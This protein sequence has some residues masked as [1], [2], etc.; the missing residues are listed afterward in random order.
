M[1]TL[2]IIHVTFDDTGKNIIYDKLNIFFLT[3]LLSIFSTMYSYI[4][5]LTIAHFK[6][7]N[8]RGGGVFFVCQGEKYKI[9]S[10]T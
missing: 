8:T 9:K 5:G 3:G 4:L 2:K 7:G 1:K 6:N 10:S